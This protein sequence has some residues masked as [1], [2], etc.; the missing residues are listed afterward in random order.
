MHDLS[1]VSQL[2]KKR[3][4]QV[5]WLFIHSL[6]W[7]PP[8]R[9]GSSLLWDYEGVLLWTEEENAEIIK[10]AEAEIGWKITS[11]NGPDSISSITDI[12]GLQK[13]LNFSEKVMYKPG[14]KLCI[15][16]KWINSYKPD[17]DTDIEDYRT[18]RL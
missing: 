13:A 1:N 4:Y 15:L 7:V 6:W 10:V 17:L 16:S 11:S 3:L 9:W 2:L 5:N 8:L 18:L 12:R 14:F